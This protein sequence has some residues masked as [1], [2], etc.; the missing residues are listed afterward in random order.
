MTTTAKNYSK[1]I[2]NEV[3][4]DLFTI[5]FYRLRFGD[6]FYVE[7]AGGCEVTGAHD[8]YSHEM[9]DAWLDGCENDKYVGWSV[10]YND[11]REFHMAS[12]KWVIDFIASGK[13]KN[14]R[15]TRNLFM[16]NLKSK[17]KAS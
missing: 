4:R 17:L 10:I 15:H 1:I 9:L 6:S 2:N 13:T 12:P 5:G 3:F 14:W 8:Y 7:V 16:K 11:G